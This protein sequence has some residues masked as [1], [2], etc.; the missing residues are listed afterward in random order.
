MK[1]SNT[2]EKGA[3]S[4]GKGTGRSWMASDNDDVQISELQQGSVI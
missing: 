1:S 2:G 4:E 3:R